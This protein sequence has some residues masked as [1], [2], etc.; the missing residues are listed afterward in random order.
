MWTLAADSKVCKFW[1]KQKCVHDETDFD[2]VFQK[3]KLKTVPGTT[4]ASPKVISSALNVFEIKFVD[5]QFFDIRH[6]SD[7]DI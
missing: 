4:I 5:N 6:F 3:A 7:R 2:N 1:Y